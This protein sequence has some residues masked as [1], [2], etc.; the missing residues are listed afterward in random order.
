[1]LARDPE[2]WFESL[3]DGRRT[4]S[5]GTGRTAEEVGGGESEK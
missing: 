4:G 5:I 1:M 3:G 2:E